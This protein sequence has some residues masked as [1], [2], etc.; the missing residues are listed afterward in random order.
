[1]CGRYVLSTPGDLLAELFD[2]TEVPELSPRYNVAPTQEVAVVRRDREGGNRLGEIRW[3]LVPSWA[4]D[5][6]IGNRMINA[7][8]ETA[9]E[10]PAFREAFARRRC[11][12]PTNGFYEWRSWRG[13]KLPYRVHLAEAEVMPLAGLWERWRAPDG[14]VL[15]SFTILTR[16]AVGGELRRIHDRMPVVLP[17]RE[18]WS[19]WLEGDADPEDLREMILDVSPGDLAIDPVSQRVN[20]VANDDAGVLEAREEPEEDEGD[21]DAPVAEQKSLF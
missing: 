5:P 17:S 21:D 11:V 7:R 16:D 14:D 13:E 19:R 9:L 2:L 15:D 6:S 20:N 10:K 18:I 1:M 8:S 3:G 4:D 12:V